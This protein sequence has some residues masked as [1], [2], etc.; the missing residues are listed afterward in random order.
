M[1]N[2][3]MNGRHGVLAAALMIVPLVLAG[4]AA[5]AKPKALVQREYVAINH[6]PSWSKLD[7]R[8]HGTWHKNPGLVQATKAVQAQR[9]NAVVLAPKQPVG[10]RGVR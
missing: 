4:T 7:D 5:Q 2:L 1:K 8:Q 3:S 6:H 10:V 9:L